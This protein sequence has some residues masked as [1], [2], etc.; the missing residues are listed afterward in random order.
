MYYTRDGQASRTKDYIYVSTWY[1]PTSYET[2]V[3]VWYNASFHDK[4]M[5]VFIPLCLISA[6]GSRVCV[7]AF[8]YGLANKPAASAV[9]SGNLST[10][11]LADNGNASS[12]PGI[13]SGDPL[14]LSVDEIWSKTRVLHVRII[15]TTI[16]RSSLLSESVLER[17][18]KIFLRCFDGYIK[19]EKYIIIRNPLNAN[20]LLTEWSRFSNL[21]Y[22]FYLNIC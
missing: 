5:P 7:W 13:V 1:A 22:S 14:S 12:S 10:C 18:I 6:R 16:H 20:C 4:W 9:C 19:Y 21:Q 15:L 8:D 2:N 17:A 3:S 11:R